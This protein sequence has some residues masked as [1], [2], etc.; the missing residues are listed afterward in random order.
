MHGMVKYPYKAGGDF[1]GTDG[2]KRVLGLFSG[3]SRSHQLYLLSFLFEARN[4]QLKTHWFR[5][6][7]YA[8]LS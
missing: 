5:R 3:V 2:Y 8:T 7:E 1:Q 6:K 4:S